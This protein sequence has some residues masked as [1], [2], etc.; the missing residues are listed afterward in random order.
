[1]ARPL[2]K[3]KAY[4]EI[5]QR[6]LDGRF[7]PGL[8]LAERSLAQ[9]LA[10]SKTPVRSA[11]DRLEAE[12]FLAV[13]PQQGIVV[14]E[15]SFR[16]ITDHFDTRIALEGFG[17]Q[18]LAGRLQPALVTELRANLA[19]QHRCLDAGDPEGYARVD[20]NFHL[21][22]GTALHNQEIQ[23]VL[24]RQLE[25]LRRVIVNVLRQDPARAAQSTREH[26]ALLDALLQ[27]E[28]GR[29]AVLMQQHLDVA[30]SYLIQNR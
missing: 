29:A 19:E 12:G 15:P 22:L 1:M 16:E 18:R 17:M 2:L 14:R 11:I 27:D 28:P 6:I 20:T 9:E 30:K 13:A 3:E 10:M 5:K 25:K 23:R 21:V 7:E 24:T 26:E 8:F 4:T